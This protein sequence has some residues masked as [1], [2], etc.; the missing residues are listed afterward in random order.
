MR[1]ARPRFSSQSV[2]HWEHKNMLHFVRTW[3]QT[4]NNFHFGF[5]TSLLKRHIKGKFEID[6]S[7]QRVVQFP[8]CYCN[9]TLS[10]CFH[11]DFGNGILAPNRFCASHARFI[12]LNCSI[13]ANASPVLWKRQRR[14]TFLLRLSHPTTIAIAIAAS[15]TLSLSWKR[16]LST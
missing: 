1:L 13:S 2:T 11:I 6:H 15:V 7:S 8:G 12:Y 14:D 3:F 10:P 9:P 4:F 16:A 5:L